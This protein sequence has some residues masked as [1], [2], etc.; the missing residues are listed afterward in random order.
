MASKT[1]NVS[2]V[3]KYFDCCNKNDP[4]Q[5][6]TFDSLFASNVQF[7]DPAQSSKTSSGVQGLKQQETNYIKA[8]PNKSAK[9]D[10]IFG[11]EDRVVVRWTCSGTNSGPYN[12]MPPKNKNFKISGISIYRI[13][14]DKITEVWQNWDHFGL[15]EQLGQVQQ[16]A[17]SR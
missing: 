3:Q 14:N 15:L 9:I 5:L 11:I 4:N 6:N 10:A 12:N 7:H 8:F 16:P 1:N 2:L 13:A 17:M